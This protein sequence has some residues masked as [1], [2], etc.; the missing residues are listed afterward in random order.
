MHTRS[1]AAELA[2]AAALMLTPCEGT[3]TASSK[4]SR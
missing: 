2:A 3:D 1:I 4:P